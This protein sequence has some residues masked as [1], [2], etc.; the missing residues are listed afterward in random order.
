MFDAGERLGFALEAG[1]PF[2]IGRDRLRQDLHRDLAVEAFVAGAVHL[3]HSA[4]AD[5]VQ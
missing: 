4:R 5:K 1:Q 3:A 2:G